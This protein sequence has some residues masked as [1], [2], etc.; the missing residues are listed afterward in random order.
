M[1]S[2]Q[3]LPVKPKVVQIRGCNG[4]RQDVS[5]LKSSRI[6]K[7]DI[8]RASPDTISNN[9]Q[10]SDGGGLRQVVSDLKSSRI[11]E[12]DID[13]AL[14]ESVSNSGGQSSAGSDAKLEGNDIDSNS[15]ELDTTVLGVCD[16]AEYAGGD[17]LE[18]I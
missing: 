1:P 8:G 16:D 5:V 2:V 17:V 15:L 6:V 11:T 4:L 18:G 7:D 10:I 9:V 3:I 13:R 14:P 12:D